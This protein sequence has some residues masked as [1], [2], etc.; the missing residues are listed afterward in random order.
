[1]ES[2]QQGHSPA[3]GGLYSRSNQGSAYDFHPQCLSSLCLPD[4]PIKETKNIC[5]RL[6]ATVRGWCYFH[7]FGVQLSLS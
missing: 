6:T 2:K 4:Q 3:S 5:V 7:S 1:M